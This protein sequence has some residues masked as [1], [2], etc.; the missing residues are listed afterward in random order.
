MRLVYLNGEPNKEITFV[1]K[2]TDTYKKKPLSPL[3]TCVYSVQL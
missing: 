2:K 3:S 1:M